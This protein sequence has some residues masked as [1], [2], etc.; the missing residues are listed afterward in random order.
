MSQEKPKN[1][2]ALNLSLN[3]EYHDNILEPSKKMSS[4]QSLGGILSLKKRKFHSGNLQKIKSMFQKK[5]EILNNK[6]QMN[7]SISES[8]QQDPPPMVD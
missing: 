1:P 2:D 6:E 7:D 4:S 8:Q 5:N 3:S